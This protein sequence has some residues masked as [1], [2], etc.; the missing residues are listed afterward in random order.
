MLLF[1]DRYLSLELALGTKFEAS[2]D[3]EFAWWHRFYLVYQFCSP[4]YA[5]LLVRSRL[6]WK[7]IHS[8]IL[9]YH[10]LSYLC[11]LLFFLCCCFF[12]QTIIFIN[13]LLLIIIIKLI[14]NWMINSIVVLDKSLF[15]ILWMPFLLFLWKLYSEFFCTKL[16]LFSSWLFSFS[17]L[18]NVTKDP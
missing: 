14:F 5:F 11:Y 7:F 3:L 15:I 10:S 16:P 18:R 8:K 9:G 12:L 1:L 4:K 6:S 13:Q 17:F 2:F